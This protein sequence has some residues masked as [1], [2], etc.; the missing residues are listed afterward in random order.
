MYHK[1]YHPN[2]EP[3]TYAQEL[4][5]VHLSHF[6]IWTFIVW[7][8]YGSYWWRTMG[9]VSKM[10]RMEYKQKR[11][12]I[13]I[14]LLNFFFVFCFCFLFVLH[15][16]SDEELTTEIECVSFWSIPSLTFCANLE[17]FTN[18]TLCYSMPCI[19]GLNSPVVFF[20][21]NP[22]ITEYRGIS[23]KTYCWTL[24]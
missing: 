12:C 10:V 14:C 1:Y 7:R 3:G 11:T 21:T 4:G 18:P 5:F 16:Y 24:I 13:Y 19:I 15:K 22:S 2:K 6:C 17:I 9:Y 20:N 23:I 8:S